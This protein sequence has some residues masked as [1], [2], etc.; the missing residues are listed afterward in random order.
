MP[1]SASA[2]ICDE[3]GRE[4]EAG[5]GA[6]AFQ[7][8]DRRGLARD[9]AGDRI[10]D[11]DPAD[12]ERGDAD[13]VQEKSDPVDE[14]LQR[15]RRIGAGAQLPAGFRKGGARRAHPAGSIAPPIALG[16]E[17]QP[18]I[19]VHQRTGPDQLRR[20]QRSLCNG[21]PRTKDKPAERRGR[22]RSR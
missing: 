13:Q 2:R 8:G 22:A 5:R 9:I 21:D 15:G 14:P 16:S 6:E 10:A 1:I 17:T 7:R 20:R 11:A 4:D 18:V 19:I 3:I 12:Q